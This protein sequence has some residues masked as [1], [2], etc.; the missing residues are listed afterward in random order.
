MSSLIFLA[1]ITSS[2]Y[3][4]DVNAK[5]AAALLEKSSCTICHSIEKTKVGPSFQDIAAHYANPSDEV[6]AYL[7][8][9]LPAEYLFNKVRAGTK[10]ENRNWRNSKEGRPY[11]KMAPNPDFL[12][13][14]ADLKNLLSFIL[15]LAP[16]P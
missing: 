11:G 10:Q 15:S 8:N 3:A 4:D 16:K 7:A 1:G 5:S 12:I 2:A 14:D 13:S 9:S 6:K